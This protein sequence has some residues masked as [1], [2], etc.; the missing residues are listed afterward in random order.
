MATATRAA[1]P[2][3]PATIERIIRAL[4]AARPETGATVLGPAPCPI[5][6]IRGRWRWHLLLKAPDAA[7][8]S[9]LA[10]YVAAR[11]PVRAGTRLVVDRDPASLL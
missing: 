3:S 1:G 10:R 5:G 9:G 6:R 8:L 11:A 2:A 4:A 7:R